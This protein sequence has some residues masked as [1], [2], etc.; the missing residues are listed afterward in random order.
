ME[1]SLAPPSLPEEIIFEEM[2]PRIPVKALLRFRCVSKSWYSVIASK[3]FIKSHLKNSIKS[4]TF[5]HHRILFPTNDGFKHW[6]LPSLFNEPLTD[7]IPYDAGFDMN[8]VSF[9]GFCN[10]LVC[11]LF[12]ELQF[13]LW[14]PATK[15]SNFLPDFDNKMKL[16]NGLITK[17]GFGYD[18]LNDDYKVFGVLFEFCELGIRFAI[19][20]VY[21][22]RTNSWNDI[23]GKDDF[24]FDNGGKY[25]NGKLHW[26]RL[27]T[28]KRV[29]ISFDLNSYENG[30]VELPSF[31]MGDEHR[32]GVVGRCLSVNCIP[33]E[34][35]IDVWL[36]KDYGVK[37]CWEK[38]VTV[39]YYDH[40]PRD[41]SFPSPFAIGP[42]GEVLLA[43]DSTF[44]IYNPEG[45]IV[46]QH[47]RHNDD[48]LVHNIGI[49]IESLAS[50][51]PDEEQEN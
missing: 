22:L 15:K 18:E 21:S 37:E 42:N 6:S 41:Y 13:I 26:G 43:Y 14:N 7:Q 49:Y 16:K 40:D 4:P 45:L 23:K 35:N 50:V 28:N 10:G 44:M 17:Y 25:V 11:V 30:V 46:L 31:V 2:L 38:V 48:Y 12:H 27:L 8:F 32:L 47:P 3:R 1:I 36:L 29:I 9:V 51:V 39:P 34:G 19:R 33:R 5:A 24:S 20:K